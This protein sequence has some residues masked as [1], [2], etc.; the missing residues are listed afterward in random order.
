M[1]GKVEAV[2]LFLAEKMSAGTMV[3]TEDK[4]YWPLIHFAATSGNLDIVKLLVENHAEIEPRNE[5]YHRGDN[6]AIK[7][8]VIS[9]HVDIVDYL[10][11]KGA[12]ASC[13]CYGGTLGELH[14][15]TTLLARAAQ[16]GNVGIVKSLLKHG[17]DIE[18]SLAL[19]H[20]KFKHSYNPY[21]RAIDDS[22]NERRSLIEDAFGSHYSEFHRGYSLKPEVAEFLNQ[23]NRRL[24]DL[25]RVSLT[26]K[27]NIV[28][29]LELF[30]YSLSIRKPKEEIASGLDVLLEKLKKFDQHLQE[31]VAKRDELENSYVKMAKL[32]FDHAAGIDLS[33]EEHGS[34]SGGEYGGLTTLKNININA[35]NF[36][37]VSIAGH[38]V[39][40]E[41]L[42]KR[43]LKGAEKSLVC[44]KDLEELKDADR[45]NDLQHRID[46]T[47]KQ[48]CGSINQDGIVNLIPLIAAVKRNDVAS[49]KAR[50]QAGMDPN[51]S[52]GYEKLPPI[53]YAALNGNEEIIEILRSHPKFNIKTLADA[54]KI[55]QS[56]GKHQIAEKL[57]GSQ[58]INQLDDKGLTLLHRAVEA[59]DVDQV[60]KLIAKGANVNLGGS[61]GLPLHIAAEKS[62]DKHYFGRPSPNHISI[63]KILLDSGAEPDALSRYGDETALDYAGNAGSFE[64]VKLLL[65]VYK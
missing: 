32:L 37:G 34:F 59:G 65:P 21:V 8:A 29:E 49:V 27:I 3:E 48:K 55:A 12:T 54:I 60:K 63:I 14:G 46:D 9:G 22:F 50:L 1:W 30:F 36:V 56:T 19:A 23:L 52:E 33:A 24:I 38:P 18:N 43:D 15:G 17:A 42:I 26:D 53:Y 57:M 44:L 31:L 20:E 10:L 39:T 11:G 62:Y 6:S 13:L 45:K 61:D 51:D 5:Y 47:I 25:S 2:R 58:D 35:F 64:A 40:R 41:M 16:D 7:A 4:G 28:N